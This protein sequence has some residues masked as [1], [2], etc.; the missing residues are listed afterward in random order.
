MKL[1][2]DGVLHVALVLPDGRF[3]SHSVRF[4]PERWAESASKVQDVERWLEGASRD[5]VEQLRDDG[6]E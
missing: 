3:Y 1:P 6:I 2:R 4:P 5:I